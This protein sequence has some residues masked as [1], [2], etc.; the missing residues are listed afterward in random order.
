VLALK[1]YY[2]GKEYIPL[3]N[4]NVKPNQKVIIMI[5][6]EYLKPEDVENK[7]FRKYVGK[8]SNES[9]AEITE[10]LKETEKVDSNEW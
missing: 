9:Y 2:N 7:P 8:L 6:D 1:G 5:L 3:E 4:A 10:A